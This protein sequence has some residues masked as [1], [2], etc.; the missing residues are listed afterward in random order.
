L[1]VGESKVYTLTQD[2][3]IVAYITRVLPWTIRS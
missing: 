2:T 3:L 1:A